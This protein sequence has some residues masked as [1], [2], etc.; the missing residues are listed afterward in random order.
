MYFNPK[1]PVIIALMFE[2][3]FQDWS[4][5]KEKLH[6]TVGQIQHSKNVTSGGVVSAATLAMRLM[7]KASG[8]IGLYLYCVNSTGIFFMG[9]H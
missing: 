1:I 7:G 2:K 9:F 8:L 3:K 5:I 6:D 4:L